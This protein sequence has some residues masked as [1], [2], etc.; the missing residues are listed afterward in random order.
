[1]ATDDVS[2]LLNARDEASAK[3]DAV[4]KKLA[5]VAKSQINI[6]KL[7]SYGGA[8]AGLTFLAQAANTAAAG[9][10]EVREGTMS[11]REAIIGAIPFVGQLAKGLSSALEEIT[12]VAAANDKLRKSF[13]EWESRQREFQSAGGTARTLGKELDLRHAIATAANDYEAAAAKISAEYD[14]QQITL[15]DLANKGVDAVRL[16]ELRSKMERDIGEQLDKAYQTWVQQEADKRRLVEERAATEAKAAAA[17][18]QAEQDRV[19]AGYQR[20]LDL[21]SQII[22]N[23][24]RLAGNAD[25][26]ERYLIRTRYRMQIE[27]AERAG[28]AE[29]AAK[30]KALREQEIQLA[31]S[32]QNAGSGKGG[33]SLTALESRFAFSAPGYD[34][35]DLK[36]AQTTATNTKRMASGI[37]KLAQLATAMQRNASQGGVT[38]VSGGTL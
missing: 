8:A 34:S 13:A 3:I 12:G 38:I 32:K 36:A 30:L 14:R 4:E 2:I 16:A 19:F 29:S 23:R 26:A 28:D 15:N 11:V 33:G 17:A 27:E 6:G 35:P 1:M 24:L 5:G 10:K 9:F 20:Q 22:A 18:M 25:A 31:L 7:V 37:D 21:D